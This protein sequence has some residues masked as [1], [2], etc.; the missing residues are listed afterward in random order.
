M[1]A[2]AEDKINV[3]LMILFVYDREKNITGKGE[4]A[5]CQHF[6]FFPQCFENA[7][8][9][10]APKGVI[11]WEWIKILPTFETKPW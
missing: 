11:V 2:F 5:G 4:N 9:P 6:L 7:S 8:F 3:T 10:D 1:K